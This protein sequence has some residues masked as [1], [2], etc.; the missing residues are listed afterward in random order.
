[1]TQRISRTLP[2]NGPL[3]ARI[4]HKFVLH[5]EWKTGEIAHNLFKYD[6]E[7]HILPIQINVACFCSLND[8]RVKYFIF[9]YCICI[10]YCFV[11]MFEIIQCKVNGKWIDRLSFRFFKNK[12]NKLVSLFWSFCTLSFKVF[13][14]VDSCCC[15]TY[16]F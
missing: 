2:G 3:W 1:M 9:Y 8:I 6:Q 5:N 14:K 10:C 15:L 13:M 4:C 16:V 12:W 7:A 11:R